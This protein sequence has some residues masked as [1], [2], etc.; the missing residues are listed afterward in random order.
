MIKMNTA[1]NAD[2]CSIISVINDQSQD[3]ARGVD[4]DNYIGAGDQGLMLFG[5]ACNETPE[6]TPLP[7]SLAHKLAQ[8]LTSVRKNIH[9]HI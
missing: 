8:K 9:I 5:Y 2:N 4:K 7:I 3:I 6:L 1:F